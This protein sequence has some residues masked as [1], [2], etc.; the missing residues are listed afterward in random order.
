MRTEQIVKVTVDQDLC[1]GSGQCALTAED[2]FDQSDDD[3]TVV[4]LD[5]TPPAD[6][7]AD[8]QYAAARCP[9][10]AITVAE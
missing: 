8:I 6:R 7:K 1:V 3:G 9:A 10:A 4:L 5:A 2:V